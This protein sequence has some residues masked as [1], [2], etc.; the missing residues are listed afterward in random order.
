MFAIKV[1]SH[2][3][4]VN[5][6]DPDKLFFLIYMKEFSPLKQR[7]VADQN[8]CSLILCS[9]VVTTKGTIIMPRD[10]PAFPGEVYLYT[11]INKC[12]SVK[13]HSHA[14]SERS[15]RNTS[16]THFTTVL[17]RLCLSNYVIVK[18]KIHKKIFL[19]L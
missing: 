13:L 7:K 1:S 4:C 11:E 12:A 16:I 19:K 14:P 8:L 2:F 5:K 17:S 15:H 18:S 6:R 3:N 10:S 9:V